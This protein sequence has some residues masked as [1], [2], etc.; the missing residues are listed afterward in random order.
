VNDSDSTSPEN[1]FPLF[2]DHLRPVL[3]DAAK[4]ELE[5]TTDEEWPAEV[6]E[7]DAH[8]AKV[9]QTARLVERWTAGTCSREDIARLARRAIREM[10]PGPW[11]PR[12]ME[13]ADDVI[14]RASL[15][16][17]LIQ[18]RDAIGAHPRQEELDE[19]G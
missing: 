7:S 4:L 14:T 11:P 13:E 3:G 19:P 6:E 9:L 18:L 2:P 12:I 15:V 16:Q 17:E 5:L 10:E 8:L 1:E